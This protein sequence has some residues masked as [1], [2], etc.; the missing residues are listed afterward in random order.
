MKR[1]ETILGGVG[2]DQVW[3]RSKIDDCGVQVSKD[4]G[5]AGWVI[6]GGSGEEMVEKS[7]GWESGAAAKLF[8]RV[9]P[10]S[11]SPRKGA[12]ACLNDGA[13]LYHVFREH[14][15]V[16]ADEARQ[17]EGAFPCLQTT[18]ID[19]RDD[20]VGDAGEGYGSIGI[21]RLLGQPLCPD[22]KVLATSQMNIGTVRCWDLDNVIGY[23]RGQPSERLCMLDGSNI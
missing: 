19:F 5:S 3:E 16:S 11:L 8:G 23:C 18:F 4:E 7:Q 12:G 9:S 21:H 22:V 6:Y 10:T 14:S 13:R 17:I 20:V 2:Q 15:N 1:D